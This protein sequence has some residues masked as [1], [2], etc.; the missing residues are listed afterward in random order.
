MKRIL[1]LTSVLLCYLISPAIAQTD[2]HGKTES[3]KKAVVKRGNPKKK[4]CP[5]AYLGFST[6]LNNSVGIMGPQIEVALPANIGIGAGIGLSTW[7]WKTALDV[8]YYFAPCHRGWAV[9]AGIT[10]NSGLDQFKSNMPTTV[11]DRDV[12]LSL[13]PM[14]N[15]MICGYYYFRL[16]K[17]GSRFYLQGGYSIPLAPVDYTPDHNYTLTQESD[18]AIKTI[19]PGGVIIG[20]GLSFA[21]RGN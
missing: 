9:G 8:K 12:I 15:V 2:M 11:G 18:D 3:H 5:G 7:G 19:S 17:N 13:K 4:T 1:I 14:T 6:G 16:G 21:L 20:V 10:H